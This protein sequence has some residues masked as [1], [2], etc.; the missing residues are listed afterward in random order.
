[1]F[2]PGAMCLVRQR[3]PGEGRVAAT[4]QPVD[5][6]LLELGLLA[7]ARLADEQADF[8]DIGRIGLRTFPIRS[9]RRSI[10][11]ATFL[12]RITRPARGDRRLDRGRDRASARRRRGAGARLLSAKRVEVKVATAADIANYLKQSAGSELAATDAKC[13]RMA[14]ARSR[15]MSS[16]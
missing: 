4:R 16:G 11:P 6:V 2:L 9:M 3:S 13:G 15:R 5:V 10:C 8:L 14:M 12:R 7:E 1:M